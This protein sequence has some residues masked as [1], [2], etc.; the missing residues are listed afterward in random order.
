MKAIHYIDEDFEFA[1]EL[2]NLPTYLEAEEVVQVLQLLIQ[3][4]QVTVEEEQ[5]LALPAPPQTNGTVESTNEEIESRLALESQ[6]AERELDHAWKALT[7]GLEVRS[8][9]IQVVFARLHSFNPNEV[10]ALLRSTLSHEELI[11]LIH[12]LRI[13]LTDVGWLSRYIEDDQQQQE[14]SGLMSTMAINQVEESGPSDE[15]ILAIADLLTCAVDALGTNGWLLRQSIGPAGTDQIVDSLRSEV[16]T[17]LEGCMEAEFLQSY[18]NQMER[19]GS[20]AEKAGG[21]KAA[22]TIGDDDINLE[23]AMLPLGTVSKPL[24]KK[25]RKDLKEEQSRAVGKYSFERIRI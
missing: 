20:L 11:F 9:T 3:S 21:S 23:Q 7:T 15:A 14:A 10:T 12:I 18:L 5:G 16:S 19:Y 2:L 1:Q 4:M 6:A 17:G 22:K 8:S 24:L 25:S 13:E